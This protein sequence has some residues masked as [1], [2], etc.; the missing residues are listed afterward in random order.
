MN[1]TIELHDAGVFMFEKLLRIH[2][3]EELQEKLKK[4]DA[5]I[6]MLL[7]R[8]IER[9]E[10]DLNTLAG[11]VG[12]PGSGKSSLALRLA[13]E[14]RDKYGL[15][16]DVDNIT[17][18]IV[19]FM[20][21][22]EQSRAF[23][24]LDEAGVAANARRAMSAL[25]V[26]LVNLVQTNRFK[27][28]ML[29]FIAPHTRLLDINVR[30]LVKHFFVTY[31][32][33]NHVLARYLHAARLYVY[34]T[35]YLTDKVFVEPATLTLGSDKV[36]MHAVLYKHPASLDND[37]Y[38]KYLEKKTKWWHEHNAKAVEQLKELLEEHGAHEVDANNIDSV[39]KTL[40]RGNKQK[41]HVFREV[42]K[43]PLEFV[44][45]EKKRVDPKTLQ[46][47]FLLSSSTAR[48]WAKQLSAVLA[49]QGVL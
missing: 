1:E 27:N 10:N 25:N 11:V 28:N 47:K 43:N 4:D 40:T 16:F 37:I 42:L 48:D 23:V 9:I 6:S 7:K 39:I 17:F 2:S 19:D 32:I 20:K 30:I 5:I 18:T 36:Y 12:E 41:A 44:D 45:V 15:K 13:I 46:E 31:A 26:A 49:K 38:E 21:K 29:V 33:K 24:V 35:D 22:A 3:E 8:F 34:K 14:A